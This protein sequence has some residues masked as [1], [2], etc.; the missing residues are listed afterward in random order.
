MDK[1]PVYRIDHFITEQGDSHF[2]AND[3][4]AHLRDH[5]FIQTPHKHNFYLCV[6]FSTGTGAH[7]ID[8]TSYRIKPGSI[9]FL[10]PGSMHNWEISA[11]A[12]GFVFFH[13]RDFYDLNFNNRKLRDLPFFSS[14]YNS[15]VTYVSK[16]EGASVSLLFDEILKEF[17][18]VNQYKNMVLSSLADIIYLRLSRSYVA[19][20]KAGENNRYLAYLQKL[21]TLINEH[22]REIRSPAAYAEMLNISGKHLNRI[23]QASLGKTVSEMI[24]DRVI[25][26]AK[27]ILVHGD[28]TVFETAMDLGYPEQSYFNRFFK[29]QTGKSPLQF[30]EAYRK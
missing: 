5:H 8:F 1:L 24:A 18:G 16:A 22:F 29:K 12:R 6:F 30:V 28:R 19:R 14:I 20:E 2:Y 17:R 10:S 13:S 15:P 11:D 9:F 25:L 21:E 7:E 23:C 4:R 27:R 3:L 26:E